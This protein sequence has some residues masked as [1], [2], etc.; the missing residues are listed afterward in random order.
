MTTLDNRPNTALVVVDVQN[1]VVDGAYRRDEV[2]K[3]IANLVEKARNEEVPVVWVQHADDELVT[4]SDDWRI[5]PELDPSE[6]EPLI[7]KSYGDSF[8]DTALETVLSGPRGRA[9]DR[10]GG[11]DRRLHPLDHSWGLDEGL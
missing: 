11:R 9:P 2:V 7:P 5:V 10:G 6:E 3:N 1:G 4:G 8:E